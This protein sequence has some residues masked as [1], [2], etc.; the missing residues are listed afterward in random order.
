[1]GKVYFVKFGA[2]CSY[3]WLRGWGSIVYGGVE[4]R[5]GP[6]ATIISWNPA[7]PAD[8]PSI[9]QTLP[10]PLPL[11]HDVLVEGSGHRVG[12]LGSLQQGGHGDGQWR[13]Q[14]VWVGILDEKD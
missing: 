12:Q 3:W 4:A 8:E 1:M 13:G 5:I 14:L 11:P 7:V 10:L 9:T 6:N 2:E